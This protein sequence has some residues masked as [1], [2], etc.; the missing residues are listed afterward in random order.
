[1]DDA[2][3]AL[4]LPHVP[5]DHPDFNRDPLPFIRLA[6]CTHPWLAAS[7]FGYF[8]HGYHATKALTFMDG[9]LRPS[10]DEIFAFYDVDGTPWATFMREQLLGHT[11][12]RHNR[13]RKSVGDAFMPRAILAHRALIRRIVSSLLDEWAPLGAFDFTA[14][15][16]N[17]PISVLCGLLG[18]EADDIPAM[19]ALFDAIGRILA[20]DA[21]D[22]LL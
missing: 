14:F 5:L 17:F 19:D 13:I 2:V 18:T 9:K 15:A 10:F 16:A 7:D 20:R 22:V 11:G 12:A 6:R 21:G 3:N 1:M 4:E 8:V